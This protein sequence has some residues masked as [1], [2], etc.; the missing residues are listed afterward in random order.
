[1]TL[2]ELYNLPFAI[3][4]MVLLFISVLQIV[5]IGDFFDGG[6]A[7]IDLD[8]DADGLSADG[9]GTGGGLL[10]GA[11]SLLG[12]GRMPFLI[13]LMMLIALYAIIGLAGQQAA[14]SL[15]GDP[16]H[17]G[18]AS[19][20]AGAAAVP[21]NGALSRPIARLLPKDETTAVTLDSLVRRDAEVQIGTARKGS[22]ARTKVV[23][24]FGHPHF[25]MVEPHDPHAA[26]TEGETVLLVRR[27]GET[28]YAVQYE[29]PKLGLD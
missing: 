23:D 3:A 25:V 18:L 17:T 9:L 5:G 7:D 15:L 6:D 1:M 27:E 22:P 28:F 13:W 29:H 26:L 4:L 24:R 10:E 16:L 11:F 21:A 14:I 2:F 19:L 8:F 20:L 12:L